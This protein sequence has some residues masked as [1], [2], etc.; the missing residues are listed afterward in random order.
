MKTIGFRSFSLFLALAILVGGMA[1]LVFRVYTNGAQWINMPYNGHIYA[2]DA[3]LELGQVTDRNGIV[4]SYSDNGERFYSDNE[5]I[6]LSTLHTVGDSQ[7]Y[8]GTGVQSTMLDTLSGYNFITGLNDTLTNDSKDISLTIDANLNAVAYSAM[9]N[10]KGAVLLYNYKTGEILC[11]VSAPTF[12]PLNVPTD[13]DSNPIYSGAYVDNTISSTYTPGSIYKLVTAAAVIENIPDWQNLTYNCTERVIINDGAVICRDNHGTQNLQQA[14]GNS[15]NIYFAQ[16]S[17]NLG[18]NTLQE[19]SEKMGFNNSLLFDDFTTAKST[20][21]L[22][23]ANPLELAWASVG[24]HTV[25]ANPMHMLTLAGAIANGGTAV[26]PKLLLSEESKTISFIDESTAFALDELMR[27]TVRDY[28]G[29]YRF[30]GFQLSAKTGTAEVGENKEPNSWMMGYSQ[31]DN[32]PYA[33]A[34]VIEEGNS[35]IDDAGDVVA[36]LFA[37]LS[38][39]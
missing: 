3:S 38:K 39:M 16:V 34:V 7:A 25:L 9:N 37:Y 30:S 31:D 20:V 19:M 11:K 5:L 28:Y 32:S 27:S 8:I 13:I 14:L 33:F 36:E 35:G 29:D 10:K 12:D 22:L 1:L 18:A 21:N 15:C 6:K 26:V 4:L 24:Q 23:S 2:E 17:Q